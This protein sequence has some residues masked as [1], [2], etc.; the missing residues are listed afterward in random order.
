[1]EL[2]AQ[3]IYIPSVPLKKKL[4]SLRFKLNVIALFGYVLPLFFLANN[5]S[6]LKVDLRWYV[7]VA[8]LRVSF[9][10]SSSFNDI[11]FRKAF[12]KPDDTKLW[13]RLA[14]GCMPVRHFERSYQN[15]KYSCKQ[16]DVSIILSGHTKME[17]THVN[18][19]MCPAVKEMVGYFRKKK[20]NGRLADI[21]FIVLK[22]VT[23]KL[24]DEITI[25]FHF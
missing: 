7:S 19:K 17:S 22:I 6:L 10:C 20:K 25:R 23:F 18:R 3:F 5:F 9:S 14:S 21:N 2:K 12:L 16:K 13:T 8:F 1:M 4:Y 15:E 11:F 24:C